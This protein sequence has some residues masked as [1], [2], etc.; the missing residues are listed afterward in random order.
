MMAEEQHE[1]QRGRDKVLG[2]LGH[3]QVVNPRILST[4]K[5]R[6]QYNYLVNAVDFSSIPTHGLA[7]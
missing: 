3:R 4:E 5:V 6:L 7:I 2:D 1:E